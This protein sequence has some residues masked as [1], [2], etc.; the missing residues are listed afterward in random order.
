METTITSFVG[1]FPKLIFIPLYGKK[2]LLNSFS[3]FSY[4]AFNICSKRPMTG[5][6]KAQRNSTPSLLLF[7]GFVS[8]KT[9]WPINTTSTKPKQTW[10]LSRIPHVG[11]KRNNCDT[12][13]IHIYYFFKIFYYFSFFSCLSISLFLSFSWIQII[14]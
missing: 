13:P 5:L 6:S 12:V 8:S 3:L 9:S 2:L 11:F 14:T 1:F 7:L 4:F 10:F